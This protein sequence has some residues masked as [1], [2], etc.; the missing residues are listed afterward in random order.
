MGGIAASRITTSYSIDGKIL[1]NAG[2]KESHTLVVGELGGHYHGVN[3]IVYNYGTVLS[4]GTGYN[5]WVGTAGNTSTVGSDVPHP[6][7]QPT[8]IVNKIIYA[9]V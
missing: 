2:G 4:P 9:G 1:G 3:P 7:V 6:N 8:A 5:Y